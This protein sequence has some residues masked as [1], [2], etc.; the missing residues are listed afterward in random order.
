MSLN[1][2]KLSSLKD[3]HLKEEQATTEPK[4]EEKKNLVKVEIKKRRLNK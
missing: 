3:K 4:V 1:E 2:Y